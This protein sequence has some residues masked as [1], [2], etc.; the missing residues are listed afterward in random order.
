MSHSRRHFLMLF[1]AT[2]TLAPVLPGGRSLAAALETGPH[3]DAARVTRLFA[4]PESARIVGESYLATLPV[5]PDLDELLHEIFPDVEGRALAQAGSTG[6][7]SS[8]LD[9]RRR[10]DFEQGRV[11]DVAGWLLSGTEA[12]LCALAALT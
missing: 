1:A 6:E 4:H 9:A 10:S 2:S 7:L 12:R 3:R 5:R 11:V 8:W